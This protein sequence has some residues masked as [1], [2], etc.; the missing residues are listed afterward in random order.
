MKV[1][2]L[3]SVLGNGMQR[4]VC[5]QFENVF[6]E[7]L[8]SLAS[9]AFRAEPIHQKGESKFAMLRSCRVARN[10]VSEKRNQGPA[11]DLVPS[12]NF[13]KTQHPVN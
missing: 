1:A 8:F 6:L 11:L 12:C 2:I 3:K 13:I 10:E 7:K 4:A 9:R 5:M